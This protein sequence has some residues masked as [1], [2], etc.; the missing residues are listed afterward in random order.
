MFQGLKKYLAS[1]P[2]LSK[3]VT[4]ETLFLYLAVSKSAVSGA[5]V[6]ED[7]GVQ[8]C[9]YYVSKSLLSTE[10][11]YQ[12]IEKMAFVLFVILRKLKYYF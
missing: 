1:P 5:F 8:K 6:R 9:V 7:R 10:T 2:L 11:R 3:P 12:K 4:G